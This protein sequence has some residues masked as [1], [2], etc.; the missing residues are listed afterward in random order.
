MTKKH[1]IFLFVIIAAVIGIFFGT[2]VKDSIIK[3]P[4]AVCKSNLMEIHQKL[5]IMQM[6]QKIDGSFENIP[7]EEL[8]KEFPGGKVPVCPLAQ[9]QTKTNYFWEGSYEWRQIVVHC[10]FKE[11]GHGVFDGDFRRGSEEWNE[12]LPGEK[13]ESDGEEEEEIDR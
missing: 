9:D 10:T 1:Y 8:A 2:G 11:E 7:P 4:M 12:M 13:I 5:M 6:E 3:T